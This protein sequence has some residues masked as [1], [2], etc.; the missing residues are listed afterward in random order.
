MGAEQFKAEC[1]ICHR[2]MVP[3]QT[4][5]CNRCV[6]MSDKGTE[7]AQRLDQKGAATHLQSLG[8]VGLRME[9][10]M[11]NWLLKGM[12][13]EVQPGVNLD[14]GVPKAVIENYLAEIS[15]ENDRRKQTHDHTE[16]ASGPAT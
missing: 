16:T 12:N 5:I 10:H 8:T 15:A 11:A 3:S 7:I 1:K 4:G 6:E 9:E 2:S 13:G 14:I